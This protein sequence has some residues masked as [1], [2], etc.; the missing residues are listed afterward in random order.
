MYHL[1]VFIFFNVNVIHLLIIDVISHVD[2]YGGD[3][4]LILTISF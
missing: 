1:F 3:L 2:Y 4:I